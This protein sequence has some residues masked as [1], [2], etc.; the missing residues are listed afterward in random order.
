M[1]KLTLDLA[2]LQVETFVA[3]PGRAGGGTVFG[4]GDT[5]PGFC[6]VISQANP[7]CGGTQPTCVGGGCDSTAVGDCFCTEAPTCYQCPEES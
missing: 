1:H 3:S 6:I 2:A 5:E 4:L 7:T